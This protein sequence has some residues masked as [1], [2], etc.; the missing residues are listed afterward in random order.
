M[1]LFLWYNILVRQKL[2]SFVTNLKN[3]KGAIGIQEWRWILTEEGHYKVLMG[4]WDSL[5]LDIIWDL[6]QVPFLLGPESCLSH[7]GSF[8]FTII[9][10]NVILIS[11][12]FIPVISN[13]L[14]SQ[15]FCL[16]KLHLIYNFSSLIAFHC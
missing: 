2:V 7:E 15:I 3:K 9:I 14:T 8:V 6:D 11:A 5:R 16:L 12:P 4:T 1:L 10:A 13:H